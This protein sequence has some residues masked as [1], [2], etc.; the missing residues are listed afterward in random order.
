[1]Q[2]VEMPVVLNYRH[3]NYINKV[4]NNLTLRQGQDIF[5]NAGFARISE[6]KLHL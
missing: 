3:L 6:A 1:M 4:R 5:L 2:G